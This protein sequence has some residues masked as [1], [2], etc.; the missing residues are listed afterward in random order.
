[1]S[2]PISTVSVLFPPSL[3]LRAVSGGLSE[4]GAVSLGSYV[5][6]PLENPEGRDHVLLQ[7]QGR[8]LS[9]QAA[10]CLLPARAWLDPARCWAGRGPGALVLCTPSCLGSSCLEGS[11]IVS[12]RGKT[13]YCCSVE[14][15]KLVLASLGLIQKS[16]EEGKRKKGWSKRKE[17]EM[18][19]F[20]PI[21]SFGI[22][23]VF[24]FGSVFTSFTAR[25]VSTA[26]HFHSSLLF[27]DSLQSHWIISVHLLFCLRHP[28]HV[29]RGR[30]G[31]SRGSHRSRETW[32]S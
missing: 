22:Y 23:T 18:C 27:K 24:C 31:L 4:M 15:H 30:N 11:A 12:D 7:G 8:G 25:H 17:P 10:Q 21:H 14:A 19:S 2:H 9:I 3:E 29:S 26:L 6:V 16:G 32:H 20:L 13:T 28:G 1:M 5:L